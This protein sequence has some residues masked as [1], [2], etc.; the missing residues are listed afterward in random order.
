MEYIRNKESQNK[1]KKVEENMIDILMATYNGERYLDVQISSIVNQTYKDWRLYIRDDGSLDNTVNIIKKWENLDNRIIVIQ[2]EKK[3]GN[4]GS[5]FLE[6]LKYS[7]A[8]F[9]CF[10]DQD[11]YWFENKL[12]KMLEV[13]NNQIND[14]PFLVLSNCFIWEYQ[15]FYIS[16]KRVIYYADTLEQYLFMNGGLQGCAM[17]FNSALRNLIAGKEIKHLYMHDH[18]ISLLAYTFGSVI[19]M[20]E[21]L[22]L[23]RQHESNVSIHL[24]QLNTKQKVFRS[25]LKNKYPVVNTSI[26]KS[27][28]EFFN[29][30]KEK[31]SNK[32]KVIF[33]NYLRFVNANKL[34]R[35]LIML[36][37]NFS[38][39][40]DGKFKLFIKILL[41]G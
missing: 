31:M 12:E 20:E 29:I 13:A 30:Y 19:Y 1:I 2:D 41:R 24:E 23:Y 7:T 15:K 18:I 16:L 5:N 11:D 21:P 14:K 35:I 25:N 39:G 6:L 26:Y 37:N 36:K 17:L 8:D 9:I 38:L 34:S 40:R 3:I 33:Q 10:C 32:S 22:F 4:P 28:E 27:I